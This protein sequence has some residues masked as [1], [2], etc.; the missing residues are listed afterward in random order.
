MSLGAA[1]VK[2]LDPAAAFEPCGV[3]KRAFAPLQRA[4]DEQFK[5][6]N[7]NAKYPSAALDPTPWLTRAGKGGPGYEQYR[8]VSLARHCLDVMFLGALTAFLL[9]K[10]EMLRPDL[11]P[12]DEEGF[13]KA[14]TRVLVI[15]LFHDADKYVGDG[16]SRSPTESDVETV[17]RD[18]ALDRHVQMTSKEIAALVSEIEQ[19]G[20]ANALLLPAISPLD[21]LLTKAVALADRAVG[22]AAG[23]AAKEGVDE[24]QALV[25]SFSERLRQTFAIELPRQRVF[26]LRHQPA[27]LR[28]IQLEILDSVPYRSGLPPLVLGANGEELTFAL[29]E[30]LPLAELLDAV[31]QR[32]QDGRRPSCKLN[33]TDGK[34]TL[35]QVKTLDN[36]LDALSR[37]TDLAYLLR[38]HVNDQIAAQA[39]VESWGGAHG[40]TTVSAPP[41]LGKLYPILG[42]TACDTH[43]LYQPLAR[44]LLAAVLL[45]GGLRN[46]SRDFQPRVECLDSLL[47]ERGI[48]SLETLRQQF[49]TDALQDGFDLATRQTIIALQVASDLNDGMA[50]RE[51]AETLFARTFQDGVEADEEDDPGIALILRDLRRQLGLSTPA[52]V[53]M[54]PYAAAPDGGTCLLCGVP[55]TTVYQPSESSIPEL[56]AT[57]FSNRIGHRKDIYSESGAT[58]LCAGCEFAQTL[59]GRDLALAGRSKFKHKDADVLHTATPLHTLILP[60]AGSRAEAQE[61]GGNALRLVSSSH[62]MLKDP[63]EEA[64]KLVPWNLDLSDSPVLYFDT[65]VPELSEQVSYLLNAARFAWL[66]GNPVHVFRIRQHR[67][68]GAFISELVPPLIDD[69]LRPA[70]YPDKSVCTV[71]RAQLPDFIAR[72]GLIQALLLKRENSNLTVLNDLRLFSWWPV[73]WFAARNYADEK[74]LN[75]TGRRLLDLARRSFTMPER[76]TLLRQLAELATQIQRRPQRGWAAPGNLQGLAFDTALKEFQ[77]WRLQQRDTRDNVI[78]AMIGQLRANLRRGDAYVSAAGQTQEEIGERYHRFAETAYDLFESYSRDDDLNSK[79]RRYLRSAYVTYFLEIHEAN[80]AVKSETET[81]MNIDPESFELS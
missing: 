18:L 4:L 79:T 28:E 8:A 75:Q 5:R 16:R 13:V 53:E 73:A 61:S 37:M 57:A 44:A 74:G 52:S 81:P 39:F 26:R 60:G 23:R 70:F 76:D 46:P 48:A 35:G 80:R 41:E 55:T 49:G 11:A 58:Y 15:A 42:F 31:Q 19:R 29:P 33:R 21:G 20:L 24:D 63:V 56:K 62:L 59:L 38:V 2:E 27:I 67:G 32:L 71:E 17:Y 30:S 54:E 77:D 9:W 65:L 1:Q 3:F 36:L 64:L 25:D 45:R 51:L 14:L 66:S 69:L 10:S 22:D 43:D 47:R 12:D 6:R 72:L 40:V 34:I 68:Y 50:F 7:A 78:A